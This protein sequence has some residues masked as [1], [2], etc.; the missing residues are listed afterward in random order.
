MS[1]DYLVLVRYEDADT[2]CGAIATKAHDTLLG[3]DDLR[4][5]NAAAGISVSRFGAQTSI[6]SLAEV[7]QL[8]DE[9]KK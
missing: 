8:L 4:F 6:P 5:A 3:L 2:F 1:P 9:Y 7:R